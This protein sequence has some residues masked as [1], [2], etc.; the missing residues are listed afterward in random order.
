MCPRTA[1]FPSSVA[2]IHKERN[3]HK[4]SVSCCCDARSHFKCI[5]DQHQNN[6]LWVTDSRVSSWRNRQ[7]FSR[8]SLKPYSSQRRSGCPSLLSVLHAPENSCSPSLCL[9]QFAICYL[10][11]IWLELFSQTRVHQNLMALIAPCLYGKHFAW[12]VLE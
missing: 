12:Y 5:S 3:T 4:V 9:F 8:L 11:G 7:F 2:W 1:M 6:I 10:E